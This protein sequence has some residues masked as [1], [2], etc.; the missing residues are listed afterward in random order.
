[1]IYPQFD[2]VLLEIIIYFN[3]SV[4]IIIIMAGVNNLVSWQKIKIYQCSVV[5][6]ELD[7]IVNYCYIHATECNPFDSANG[8]ERP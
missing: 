3:L 6:C 2:L 5:R 4:V 8:P 7:V 1:M